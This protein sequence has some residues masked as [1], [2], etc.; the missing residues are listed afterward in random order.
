M[1][2]AKTALG[3]ACP[4]FLMLTECPVQAALSASL[5]NDGVCSHGT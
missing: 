2:D 1:S 3:P 4:A 5:D